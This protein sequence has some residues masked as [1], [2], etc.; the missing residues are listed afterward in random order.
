MKKLLIIILLVFAPFALTA[1]NDNGYVQEST[2]NE[3]HLA[4]IGEQSLTPSYDWTIEELGAT[5]I[6]ASSFWDDWWSLRGMFAWDEHIDDSTWYYWVEQPEHPRSSGLS[7]LLPSSGFDSLNDIGVYLLQFYT[8]SWV[9]RELLGEGTPIEETGGILF[10]SPWAFEEYD[11]VLYIATARYGSMR[12]DWT[13]ATHN[14]VQ[15]DDNHMIVVETIVTA[16]DHRGSGDEMPTATFHFTFIDGK[17]ESGIGIW[18]WP[19]PSLTDFGRIIEEEGRFWDSWRNFFWHFDTQHIVW[20]D[21]I[22]H[23]GNEFVRL[24]PSSGFENIDNIRDRL[25]NYTESWAEQLLTSEAPPFIEHNRELYINMERPRI[26]HPVWE[27]ATHILIEQEGEHAIIETTIG[28]M[29]MGEV[30]KETQLRFAFIGWQIDTSE[31][32]PHFSELAFWD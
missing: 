15:N 11:G 10:G 21:R 25:W 17:I 20:E 8:Q 12:P 13:T 22:L 32:F 19:G 30:A 24:L 2:Q 1:C 14:I 5:I 6:A 27:T 16:Y 23:N 4:T 18:T 7:I 26:A 29:Y 28:L 3:N 9:D 31:G